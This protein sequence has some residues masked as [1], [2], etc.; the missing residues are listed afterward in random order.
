[1]SQYPI[2]VTR[3]W[4]LFVSRQKI[5]G[6]KK[7]KIVKIVTIFDFCHKAVVTISDEVCRE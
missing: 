1:M 2:I 7:L 5:E 6:K 3:R 4:A